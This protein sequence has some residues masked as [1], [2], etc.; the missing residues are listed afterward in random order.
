[1]PAE[2]TEGRQRKSNE[3]AEAS[4]PKETKPKGLTPIMRKAIYV[5]A[6]AG[7]IGVEAVVA[8]MLVQ[9]T[10]QE[11]PRV[12]AEK[13]EKEQDDASRVKQTAMGLTTD[14]IQV[15]VNVGAGQEERYAKV[16][17][18]L[19]FD[20]IKY[21]KLLVQLKLRVPKIKDILIESLSSMTLEELATPVGKVKLRQTVLREV[22]RILPKDEGTVRDVF[23]SEFLLQ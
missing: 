8:Y 17:I 16:A 13:K 12:L 19:E 14:P 4:P 23:L 9:A 10:K 20:D 15:V 3:A 22:N 7:I 1:M 21:P 2:E 5:G 11:D 6:I 18:Q